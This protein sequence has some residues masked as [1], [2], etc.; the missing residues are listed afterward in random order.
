LVVAA[1]NLP[2]DSLYGLA[3]TAIQRADDG[4][5]LRAEAMAAFRALQADA[6]AAGFRI[7]CVSSYR[8]FQRQLLI[9]NAK[10]RGTRAVRDDGDA[11]LDMAALT[12]WE[13]VQAI[14]RFSA[15][16]GAS[17]HHWGTELDVYDAAAVAEN[18]R[19]S[20]SR[21]EANG[22]FAPLYGWLAARIDRGQA[23]G[24]FRPY[25]ADRGGVAPEPWHLSY[26][27]LACTLQQTWSG[28]RLRELLM[29]VDMAERDT[30]MAH[31][32]EIVARYIDVPR[33]LWPR[34]QGG[35]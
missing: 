6:A 17:R 15:L 28:E 27:P 2:A 24:F 9:W 19:P 29:G 13:R 23:R 26:A 21:A 20:L 22:P 5:A 35:A 8:D 3:D 16:P 34:D 11:V 30:V 32:P 25:A 7:A 1:A 18:Y 14:L 12:P 4:L 31:W 33:A 10:A